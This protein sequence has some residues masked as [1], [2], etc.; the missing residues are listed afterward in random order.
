[1]S[2]ISKCYNYKEEQLNIIIDAIKII[3]IRETDKVHQ[4]RLR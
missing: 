1:M 3:R 4:I 2:I